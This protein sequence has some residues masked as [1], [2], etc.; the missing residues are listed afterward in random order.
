MTKNEIEMLLFAIARVHLHIDTLET[1][2]SDRLDFHDCAV[3]CIRDALAAA[4]DAGVVLGRGA[5]AR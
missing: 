2:H 5:T 3:W 1:R 4:F